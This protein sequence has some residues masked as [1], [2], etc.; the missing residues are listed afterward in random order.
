MGNT[1]GG[2]VGD[3]AKMGRTSMEAELGAN[4]PN[5]VATDVLSAFGDSASAIGN[6]MAAETKANEEKLRIARDSAGDKISQAFVEMGPQLKALGQES[7]TQAQNEVEALREEMFAAINAKDQKAIADI[8]IRLNEMKTRHAG[9]ADNL[10]TL[11]ETWEADENGHRPVSTAAMT[12][13]DIAVMENFVG[14]DSKRVVYSEDNPPRMM[15]EWDVPVIDKKTGEPVLDGE[16]NPVTEPKRYSLQELQDKVILK[17]TVNGAKVVDYGQELKEAFKANPDNAPDAS[18]IKDKVSQMI[19]RDSKNIRDWLHGNPA[20]QPGLNVH[21]YLV[22][23]IE[24][25]FNTFTKLGVD[26]SQFGTNP[27]KMEFNFGGKTYIIGDGDG[28]VDSDDLPRE[29]KD[30]LIKNVMD[31][32]DLEISHGIISEIYAKHLQYDMIGESNKDY[33]PISETSILGSNIN[34][35]AHARAKRMEALTNLQSLK[36]PKSPI[37]TEIS[38]MTPKGIA[39]HLGFESINSQIFND[40]TGKLE[41]ISKYIKSVDDY[42]N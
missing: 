3:F 15:Y 39:E 24:D 12:K 4:A 2:S 30:D 33:R 6:A 20:E 22:D 35:S 28:D 7:Y 9:D 1:A 8:N 16:G 40:K 34:V 17:Q 27:N 25:N 32:K 18:T 21:K 31:V 36:D 29:L 11:V 19:P 26:I 5:T 42:L 37:Y 38:A 23:M 10:D 41:S 14:N 13:E